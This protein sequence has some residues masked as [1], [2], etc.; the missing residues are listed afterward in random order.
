[1]SE[2]KLKFPNTD[3]FA[4]LGIN[5]ANVKAIEHRFDAN[6]VA[7]GDT[8]TIYGNE[9]ENDAIEKVFKELIIF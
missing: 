2:K 9:H 7:R 3:M 4:L 1:M 5:D 6:I 8:I